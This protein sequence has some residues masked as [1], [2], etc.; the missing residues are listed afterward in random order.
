MSQDNE[1]VA[2]TVVKRPFVISYR[3]EESLLNRARW[4][5]RIWGAL[6][7]ILLAAAIVLLLIGFSLVYVGQAPSPWQEHPRFHR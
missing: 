7:L 2:P 1:I 4:G 5:K 3:T 6:A